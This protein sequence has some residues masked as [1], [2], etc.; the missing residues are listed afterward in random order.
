MI[1][2]LDS[3][4]LVKRALEERESLALTDDLERRH[5]AGD[6]FVASSL[7]WVETSRAIRSRLE[8]EHPADVAERMEV[9]ISGVSEVSF[10]EVVVSL[11]RRIGSTRLRS[12][13]AIHLATAISLDADLVVGYDTRLLE[14]A[15]E[16]GFVTS[17]P[18]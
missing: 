8:S 17:S 5:R 11:A 10:D 12:L 3:S 1:V 18:A 7:A 2:Y 14:C 15:E 13:D 6:S 16:L 9:A 4:A